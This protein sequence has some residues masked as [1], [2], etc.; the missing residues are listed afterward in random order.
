VYIVALLVCTVCQTFLEGCL[1]K[2]EEVSNLKDY[3]LTFRCMNIARF[4]ILLS[5][6]PI[7]CVSRSYMAW[8]SISPN[9]LCH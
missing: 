9:P 4:G 6:V 1:L 3:R 8:V 7:C 2:L 5:L